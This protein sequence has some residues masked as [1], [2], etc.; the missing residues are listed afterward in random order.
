L[1]FLVNLSLAWQRYWNTCFFSFSV[2]FITTHF[3]LAFFLLDRIYG[4]EYVYIIPC[5]VVKEIAR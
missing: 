2:H 4:L 1:L 5:V 3:F